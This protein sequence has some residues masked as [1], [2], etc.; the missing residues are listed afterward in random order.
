MQNSFS[1][2][3]WTVT[4]IVSP[5]AR[6][7]PH[8]WAKGWPLTTIHL[9]HQRSKPAA[10]TFC[11]PPLFDGYPFASHSRDTLRALSSSSNLRFLAAG[12][13]SRETMLPL[14]SMTRPD[15][16]EDAGA[17]RKRQ[18]CISASSLS[19]L[20]WSVS[21]GGDCWICPSMTPLST[22][23][24]SDCKLL[25]CQRPISLQRF[26]FFFFFFRMLGIRFQRQRWLQRNKQRG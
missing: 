21:R 23:P 17:L 4:A 5:G 7:G 8:N 1:V 12:Y 25:F 20:K 13:H 16:L 26:F 18:T 6:T 14:V 19:M 10:S 9:N 3:K 2:D 22:C 11:L 15:D 24:L